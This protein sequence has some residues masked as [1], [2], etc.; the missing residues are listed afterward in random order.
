MPLNSRAVKPDSLA[1][2][3]AAQRFDRQHP[4]EQRRPCLRWLADML[5][6]AADESPNRNAEL[7]LRDAAARTF[8]AIS[9]EA[10]NALQ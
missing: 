3:S 4:A 8:D 9:A 6:W 1:R 10:R 7:L 5:V 2:D